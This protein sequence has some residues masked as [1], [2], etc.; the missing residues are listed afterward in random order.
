LQ[1]Q[2]AELEQRIKEDQENKEVLEKELTRLKIAE[3][4]EDAVDSR[5]QTLLKG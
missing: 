5:D 2:I 3:W 1:K 4:E